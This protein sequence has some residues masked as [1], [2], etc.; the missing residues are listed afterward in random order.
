MVRKFLQTERL[1]LRTWREE[2][3]SP[4]TAMNADPQVME[5]F[6]SELTREQSYAL[7]DRIIAHFDK[8][9]FGLFAVETKADCAFIGFTGLQVCGPG[10]PIE[11][12]V[13]IGWRLARDEWRKGY[14]HEAAEAC[15]EWFWR[16]TERQRLV[17]FTSANNTPSQNLMRKLGFTHRPELDFDHPAIA[18][19]NP[20]C[21]QFV[22]TLAREGVTDV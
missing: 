14:A 19:D 15:V 2:D 7:T 13:E 10:L 8:H 6:P 20:Q 21:H 11:G 22:F 5:F 9:G 4:F 12:E 17:S 16:N 1:I 3:R 18:R